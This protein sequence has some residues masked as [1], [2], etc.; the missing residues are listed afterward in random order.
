MFEKIISSISAGLESSNI[1]YMLIGGQ[2]VLLYGEPRLTRDIDITLGVDIDKLGS[3]IALANNLELKIL[4][5]KIEEFVSKTMVLPVINEETGIRIDF[6]FSFSSY[7]CQAIARAKKVRLLDKD[8]FFASPEDLIIHKIV[9]GR[10]RDIEDVRS[11]ILKITNLDL[12]Y[13][14]QWLNDFSSASGEDDIKERFEKIMETLQ[15]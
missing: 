9:A 12:A 11:I 14:R 5:E 4:P 10:A 15:L 3:I 8:V 6:I 13:I 1:P 2:A 7:E